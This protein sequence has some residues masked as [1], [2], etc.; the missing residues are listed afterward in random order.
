AGERGDVFDEWL[1][2]KRRRP[3][4]GAF[5][6][7]RPSDALSRIGGEGVRGLFEMVSVRS[8]LPFQFSRTDGFDQLRARHAGNLRLTGGVDVRDPKP[9]GVRETRRELVHQGLRAGVAMRLEGHEQTT[10]A[11][12]LK[13]GEHRFDFRRMM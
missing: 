5:P 10:R 12:I 2:G 9:V 1:V 7:T 3:Q 8:D 6:L 11:E 13:R 4:Y